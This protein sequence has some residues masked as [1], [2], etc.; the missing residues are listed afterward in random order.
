MTKKNETD[1]KVS[2]AT[3]KIILYEAVQKNPTE[4]FIIVG[5]L[6]RAG[7]LEQYNQEKLDYPKGIV[8]PTITDEQLN[9]IIKDYIGE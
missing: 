8:K 4:H 6:A 2:T 3:K 5:A 9:K 1:K 7:L